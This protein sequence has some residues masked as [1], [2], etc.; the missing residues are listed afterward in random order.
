MEKDLVIPEKASSF[1]IHP[2]RLCQDQCFYCGGKF[3]LFDT[4]LHIAQIKTQERQKKI[5]DSKPMSYQKVT[6]LINLIFP[7]LDEEKLTADSCLCD[8]CYRHVDRRAN[9]PSYRKRLSA[10]ASLLQLQQG[11]GGP[12]EAME[13]D[14]NGVAAKG[15][16]ASAKR[17]HGML[18]CSLC[19]CKLAKTRSLALTQVSWL[20]ILISP[21]DN[22][23]L[24]SVSP[25]M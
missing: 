17:R 21:D 22:L 11:S 20:M 9:C 18:N 16:E 8:A 7:L 3:G 14:G 25:R 5:L 13:V 6:R 4:P 24:I 23:T 15:M 19:K 2:G 12:D 1:S 10:P